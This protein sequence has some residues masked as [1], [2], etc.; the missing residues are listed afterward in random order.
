[1]KQK[2]KNKQTSLLDDAGNIENI[3]SKNF[4]VV[5]HESMIPYS[6]HVILDRALPRVE[7]GLKP[8]QRRILFTMLELGIV[9]DKP[10][11][12]SARIVGDCLGKYHP[13]G[14]SSVYDAMVRMAQNF[15]MR[16]TLVSGHGNFGSIDGDSAAAMR[17]TE[18]K[19][20]PLA[21]ELLKDLEKDTVSWSFNFDDTL[22][23]PDMLPASFPNL[24]VNGASGIAVGLAT[25]I[26]THNLAEVIDATIDLIDKPKST[27]ED[28]MKRMPAP[29]FPTGGYIIA[30]E[31]LVQAYETGKGK[32]LNRAKY[33]IEESEGKKLIVITELPYQTNKALLL[34]K[35]ATIKESTGKT[36]LVGIGDIRDESDRNGMRA[37]IRLKKDFEPQP[38]INYLLKYTD[39]QCTFGINMVAIADGKPKQMGIV[40]IL[41]YYI[42]FR[43]DIIVRRS[44]FDLEVAKERAHILEGLIV[45]IKN[46]DEVIKII[47]KSKSTLDAKANLRSRFDLSDRQAQAILDMRLAKLTSLEISKIDVEL[48]ELIVKIKKLQEIISSTN[49]QLSVVKSELLSIKKVYKS[50]R[51]TIVLDKDNTEIPT[52]EDTNMIRDAI[53]ATSASGCIKLIPPKNF[54]MAQKEF[55]N[56]STL[57]EVHESLIEVSTDQTAYL[58][59]NLGNCFK[60]KLQDI[61]DAKFKEKGMPIAR[62]I[63]LEKNEKVINT[64]VITSFNKGNITIFTKNGMVKMSALSEFNVAKNS[65]TAIK[66]KEND[67]VISVCIDFAEFD[68]LVVVTKLGNL[69]VAANDLTQTSRMTSGVKLVS[70]N[71]GDYVL[72]AETSNGEGEIITLTNK[73]YGKRTIIAGIELLPRNRK[74]VK[75]TPFTKDNGNSLCFASIVKFPYSLV[76]QDINGITVAKHSEDLTVSQRGS[77]GKSI[78]RSKTGLVVHSVYKYMT[79]CET[80]AKKK[81]K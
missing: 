47:K 23:E 36:A 27:V 78:T 30:G 60:V 31:E 21:M 20:E 4:D 49:K 59:T 70:L 48:A 68:R 10:Y 80:T 32:I 79:D 37:V 67:E 28:L 13:H 57:N 66:L 50:P 65:F 51:R 41:K 74:G 6:E 24:L 22:K 52:N 25:N 9:P 19:L 14:D 45:A 58:F 64:Q 62:I 8:V 54:S 18:A 17:Y 43:Q 35:I 2:D 29:D 12:K 55:G 16:E 38:I 61:E 15:N 42:D 77:I 63:P 7:D 26:P 69:L 73:A 72:C 53:L 33:H 40:E 11:R 46:I 39:L 34:Q 44:K 71:T 1:M 75:I 56:N 76:V 3:L 5:L 81:G